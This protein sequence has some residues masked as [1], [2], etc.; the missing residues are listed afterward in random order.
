[1]H[2]IAERITRLQS[3]EILI[4]IVLLIL[5]AICITV[6]PLIEHDNIGAKI[7]TNGTSI[8]NVV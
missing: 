8:A 4:F 1:M 6:A 3:F 7:W 2:A 5:L